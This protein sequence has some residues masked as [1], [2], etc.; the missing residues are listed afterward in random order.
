VS[1]GGASGKLLVG[2][3]AI[4]VLLALFWHPAAPPVA[5]PAAAAAATTAAADRPAPPPL[6]D[7]A[8]AVEL[9]AEAKTSCLHPSAARLRRLIHDY[10][11]IWQDEAL[12]RVTCRQ[13]VIGMT[14]A[15]VR[16]AWGAPDQINTTETLASASE[17]WVYPGAR[18][19]YLD[20]GRVTAVQTSR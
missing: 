4:F 3:V 11:L 6:S 20:A 16:A 19:V 5:A 10:G 2:L 15:Q 14:A 18:Y 17:Q 12:V 1:R 7:S 8:R 13:V 9:L